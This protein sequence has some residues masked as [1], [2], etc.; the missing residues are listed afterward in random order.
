M[1]DIEQQTGGPAY[2][3]DVR[4]GLKLMTFITVNHNHVDKERHDRVEERCWRMQ[5][6]MGGG[7]A[8]HTALLGSSEVDSKIMFFR[9]QQTVTISACMTVSYMIPTS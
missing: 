6:E 3:M 2:A 8:R 5:E 1:T 7:D 4:H 9:Y